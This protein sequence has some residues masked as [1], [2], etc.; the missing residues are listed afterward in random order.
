M[1]SQENNEDN[2][3]KATAEQESAV[4]NWEWI[5]EKDE[6]QHELGTGQTTKVNPEED[7]Y[8]LKHGD[9]FQLTL[10]G[11]VGPAQHKTTEEFEYI[12][13][14]PVLGL[15]TNNGT[16]T[17]GEKLEITPEA[18]P[19]ENADE[20]QLTVSNEHGEEHTENVEQLPENWD[21]LEEVDQL[22]NSG[23]G[24]HHIELEAKRNGETIEYKEQTV[25]LEPLPLQ[26]TETEELT[27]T[28]EIPEE[29]QEH[30]EQ[31]KWEITIN[32]ETT[33]L[34]TGQTIEIN[35]EQHNL[36]NRDQFKLTQTTTYG[37]IEHEYT[38]EKETTYSDGPPPL[39]G[40][41]QP[42]QDLNEDG[43]YE[44]LTGTGEAEIFDV[45]I[46]FN[47]TDS[48]YMEENAEYFNFSETNKDE[49][50]IFDVQA[51]FNRL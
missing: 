48:E 6:E 36:E 5:L 17:Y 20:Y 42:P 46:L 3:F 8:N 26:I 2:Q 38:E 1:I 12:A 28:A 49:V 22:E 47:Y 35:P 44:D 14:P 45:Q 29:N 13:G 4:D 18:E 37:S 21:I 32:G 31:Y 40:R 15:E 16:G 10:T 19:E 23:P 24:K 25:N 39:P 43:N 34:G 33:E 9:P 7:D 51:L 11:K 50:N 27:Y 41:E 30:V